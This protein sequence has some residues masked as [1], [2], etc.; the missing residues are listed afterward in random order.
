M[1]GWSDGVEAWVES[2]GGKGGGPEVQERREGNE[3]RAEVVDWEVRM[4]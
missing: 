3:V 2:S 4:R 1:T